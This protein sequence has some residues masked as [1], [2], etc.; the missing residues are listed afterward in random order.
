MQMDIFFIKLNLI[1]HQ[2]SSKSGGKIWFENAHIKSPIQIPL[3]NISI[4]FVHLPIF[5]GLHS[6][7]LHGSCKKYVPQ[8]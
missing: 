3:Q 7:V 5:D 2:I 1:I 6:E 4:E 8:N